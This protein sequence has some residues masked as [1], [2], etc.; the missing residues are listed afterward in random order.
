MAS[1]DL[2][3][4]TYGGNSTI[5]TSEFAEVATQ[6]FPGAFT[7]ANVDTI[8]TA[9]GYASP[10]GNLTSKFIEELKLGSI[11]QPDSLSVGAF[12]TLLNKA[13]KD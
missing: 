2:Y 4:F 10:Q 12:R 8:L 9:T 3:K 6:F 11:I 7:D 1:V 5:E 13:G